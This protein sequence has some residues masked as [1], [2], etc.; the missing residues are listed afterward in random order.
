MTNVKNRKIHYVTGSR[1]DFGLMRSTLLLLNSKSGV[2]IS[3]L[4]T[5]QHTSAEYGNT[6]SEVYDSGLE[7]GCIIDVG[8]SGSSGGA[9]MASAIGTEIRGLTEYWQKNRPEVVVL[10]GDRGEML[11]AAIAAVHL[12]LHVCH[13]HGGERSGTVDE[14]VRHAISKLS[15]IHL[16][17]NDAA[18]LRLIKMG[19]L[20]EAVF[21][22]GAPGLV[23]LVKNNIKC[24]SI[25][26][27]QYFEG[28]T[29]LVALLVF[30]PVLQVP[31]K[32]LLELQVTLTTLSSKN[33]NVIILRPNS[34]SG[35]ALMDE[36]L[37]SVSDIENLYIIRHLEREQYLE[38][39]YNSDLLIGNSSSGIIEAATL[40]TP[41]VNIGIRQKL[42]DISE[43]TI[44]YEGCDIE[45]LSVVIDQ[46]LCLKPPFVNVYGDGFA[47][48]RICEILM[49]HDLPS[50]MLN[51][52][53][54]Y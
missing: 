28:K 49:N 40:G 20:E 46:A 37:N 44:S 31:E 39:L 35:G 1:A 32:S 29:G 27:D 13:I 5:G 48:E 45:T 7:V 30:H 2:S 4:V 16:A 42:R 17:S 12:N 50:W 6:L 47:D 18:R 24:R 8:L 14:S 9:E 54:T 21:V 3:V 15:H 19:E 51:K 22:A 38:V 52:S 53:L 33:I 41:V 23:N 36:Y 11:A 26:S 43:N 10:L 34:D 25:L